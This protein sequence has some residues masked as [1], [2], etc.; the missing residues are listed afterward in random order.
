M[1]GMDE[2]RLILPMKDG[3]VSIMSPSTLTPAQYADLHAVV[4][5]TNLAADLIEKVRGLST[6]WDVK[7][8]VVR[9]ARPKPS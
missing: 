5:E 4:S 7:V 2:A 3:P 1:G 8:S 6:A 9:V